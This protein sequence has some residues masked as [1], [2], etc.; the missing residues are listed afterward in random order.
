MWKPLKVEAVIRFCV[1][2]YIKEVVGIVGTVVSGY[3]DRT[4]IGAIGQASQASFGNKDRGDDKDFAT[5]FCLDVISKRLAT[6]VT[7]M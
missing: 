6:F 1:G 3:R 5:F 4:V 2:C 7:K